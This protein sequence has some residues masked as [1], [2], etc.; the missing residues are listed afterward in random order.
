MVKK[1]N[2]LNRY[3]KGKNE[4]KR[5]TVLESAAFEPKL[6]IVWPFKGAL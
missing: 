1:K 3:K 4:Q 5:P 6:N 2:K